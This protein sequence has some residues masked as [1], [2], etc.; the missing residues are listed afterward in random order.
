MVE[1]DSLLEINRSIATANG[2]AEAVIDNAIAV[3]AD[4]AYTLRPQEEHKAVGNNEHT[5]AVVLLAHAI[6]PSPAVTTDDIAKA[7]ADSLTSAEI[8]EV[9]VWISVLQLVHRITRFYS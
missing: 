9:A 8:I 4:P 5:E 2:V 1:D 7:T 3:G 6:S